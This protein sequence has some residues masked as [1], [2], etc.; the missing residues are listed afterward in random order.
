MDTDSI[1]LNFSG[2][3]LPDEHMDLSILEPPMKTNNKVPDK[4][5]HELGVE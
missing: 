1:L 3:I 5:K 2:G 4:F